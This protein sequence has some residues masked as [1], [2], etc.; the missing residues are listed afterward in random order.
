MRLS[1]FPK[2]VTLGLNI[3]STYKLCSKT[4]IIS[5]ILFLVIV[6]NTEAQFISDIIFKST[7]GTL[8]YIADTDGNRIPDYSH[9]GYRGGG[10]PLPDIPVE[11]TINPVSGDNTEHIQNAINHVSSLPVNENGFRGA[12]RLNPGEY[13]IRNNLFINTSGV[14]LRGSGD[15]NNPETDTI[16]RAATNVK[17]TVLQIGDERVNWYRPASETVAI[18][19]EFITAGSR[20]FEIEDSTHFEVGD[21]IIIRHRSSQKWIDSVDGGGTDTG[22]PWQPGYIDIFYNRYITDIN[23]NFIQIDAPVY[24]HLDTRLTD[25]FIYKPNRTHLVTESGVENLRIEI[26]SAGGNSE[27]HAENAIIFRGV[28]NGWANNVSVLHFQITGIGTHTSSRITIKNSNALE[29]H[30]RIT[31]SRR[32]NFNTMQF[33]NNILFTNVTSSHGRRDFISNG[34]SVASGVVFHESISRRTLGSSEGHQKWS[35]ALLYDNIIFDDPVHF[36]VLSLNNRGNFGSSHGWTSVHSTAWNIHAEN[37][38]IYIQ[39]PPGAQNYGIGN[40]S[41]VSGGGFFDHPA[42]YIEGTNQTPEFPSLYAKQLE[43]RLLHGIPPDMPNQFTV[44]KENNNKIILNW[45]YLTTVESSVILERSTNNSE[46]E[47]IAELNHMDSLFVDNTVLENEYRYRIFAQTEGRKSA[48]AIS[49]KVHPVFSEDII[50]DFN[51]IKSKNPL[52]I[53]VRGEPDQV[54]QIEWTKADSRLDLNYTLMAYDKNSSLSDPLF[55]KDS[56][57]QTSFSFTYSELD[58]LLSEWNL[59][60]GDSI[61]LLWKVKASSKTV[62]KYSDNSFQTEIFRDYIGYLN[63]FSLLKPSDNQVIKVQGASDQE[64]RFVWEEAESDLDITYRLILDFYGNN[65]DNPILKIDSLS[66]YWYTF[67]YEELDSLLSLH[68]VPIETERQVVWKVKASTLALDK[69]STAKKSLTFYRGYIYEI[70]DFTLI[71]PSKNKEIDI[72]GLSNTTIDFKWEEAE[73]IDDFTYSWYLDFID[74]DFSKPLIKIDSLSVNKLSMTYE[75]LDSLLNKAGI[76][77]SD[78][79]EAKWAVQV[80]IGIPAKWSTV[81]HPINLKR[82]V[83]V[84]ISD[85]ELND[86]NNNQTFEITG[87]ADQAIQ[88]SWQKVNSNLDYSYTFLMDET[89]GNFSEPILKIDSITSESISIPYK[90]IHNILAKQNVNTDEIFDAKWTIKANTAYASKNSMHTNNISFIRGTIFDGIIRLEQNYPNPF[91]SSTTIRYHLSEESNIRIQIYNIN[92]V[93]VAD[94]DKGMKSKGTHNMQ[95]NGA[96]FS[97]GIY[98]YQLQT[99]ENI[100]VKKMTLIK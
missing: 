62:T 60:V 81:E 17:G 56:L 26:E 95:F 67:T 93:L 70:S 6:Q 59:E 34:T 53:T 5:C 27:S 94:F 33:S 18:T 73:S 31:G 84:E 82:G 20:V 9:A 71:R 36:N 23:D 21:N 58:S 75:Q 97:S 47:K 12:V 45:D 90:K 37:S 22:E 30:S 55:I 1:V 52:E 83:V 15:G 10:V 48:I 41:R 89:E 40:Q 25:I 88:F 72:S 85:F 24:N 98:F 51:M 50:S 65:F 68:D 63:D 28:E 77:Y 43:E 74:E 16:I 32:Y 61:D 69:Y 79:L 38:Y 14:V 19:S 91:N 80:N 44:S 66:N 46:F 39:K 57:H 100:K 2:K 64:L 49:E 42:G 4:L 76:N 99:D 3:I 13:N 86:P 96:S 92:G 7:D 29:P 87:N 54:F 8:T 35:Q 11:M 78:Y